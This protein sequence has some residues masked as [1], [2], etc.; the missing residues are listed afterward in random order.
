M[1]GKQKKIMPDSAFLQLAISFFTLVF[2][3]STAT[4]AAPAKHKI[5]AQSLIEETLAKH[6]ELEG[7][8][9]GTTPPNSRE[10][11]DIA[12]TDAKEIGDKCD[13]G[14]LTVIKTGKPAIEKESDAYDVTEP[15]QVSGKTI[16]TIGLD[17]K[18]DQQEAGLLDRAN[19]IAKEI[20]SQIPSKSKLFEPAK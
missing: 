17:F 14:E 10:C 7:I 15:F 13:K 20:E 19:A 2:F 16:G 4:M 6:P 1:T 5:F 3:A 8:G 9:L 12:D 11:V 18:L